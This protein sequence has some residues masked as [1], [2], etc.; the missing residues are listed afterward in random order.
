MN[1]SGPRLIVLVAVDQ[2]PYEYVA[3]FDALFTGGLRRLLDQGVLFENARYGHAI[4]VTAA[5]HTTLASGLHPS[6]S[7]IIENYWYDREQ[8]ERVYSFEDPTHDR[9][10]VNF[11]GTALPDW[12]KEGVDPGARVF[13]VS[14]KDRAA[15]AMAGHRPDGVFWYDDDTGGF[16][17]STYYSAEFPDW[18]RAWNDQG[19]AL[20]WFAQGLDPLPPVVDRAA[21]LGLQVLDEGVFTP[22]FPVAFGGLAI[23]PDSGFLADIG[24]SALLDELVLSFARTLVERQGLGRRDHL[25]YLAI[26]LSSLDLAGHRYGPQSPQVADT[27]LRVDREL[28]EFLAFLDRTVGADRIVV[29]LTSDH[30]VAPIP[31][32]RV[33][34]G[35][36]AQRPDVE[37]ELCFQQAGER[38]RQRFG[39]ERWVLEN[40]YLDRVAIE[41]AGHDP[42]AVAAAVARELETCDIVERVWTAAELQ[43]AA[44]DGAEQDPFAVLYRHSFHVDRS[45]DLLPQLVEYA[46]PAGLVATHGSP[47]DYDRHVPVFVMAPGLGAARIADEVGIVDLAPTLAGLLG[48]AIPKVDGRDLT[49]LLLRSIPGSKR[50]PAFATAAFTST[51][52]A[53]ADSHATPA[54]SASR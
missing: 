28:G 41:N 44:G 38:V 31:E 20:R 43:A 54:P 23:G 9:S 34:F 35:L 26:G 5:G 21:D 45:A 39:L 49:D 3:R 30:G 46:I 22:R 36:S 53:T 33:G 32:Q 1:P 42:A 16:E 40:F 19:R 25:D 11:L 29:A 6:S 18:A 13:G 48:I 27:L 2:F 14:G 37:D 52:T 10:P 12:L 24:N 50:I 7:G 15:I 17:S 4:T 51:T 8:R 47:Y